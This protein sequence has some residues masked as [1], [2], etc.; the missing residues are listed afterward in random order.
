MSAHTDAEYTKAAKRLH[1]SE[2]EVEVDVNARVSRGDDPGAYVQAWVWVPDDQAAPETEERPMIAPKPT[3]LAEFTEG[4]STVSWGKR[5]DM[6]II[7]YGLQVKR[8]R[9]DI[10]AC[11]KFGE[12]VRHS[13][14]CA[15]KLDQPLEM[16]VN[17]WAKL[18]ED[19]MIYRLV[20]VTPEE[21]RPWT[22]SL[23]CCSDYRE[24]FGGKFDARDE[25]VEVCDSAFND[26]DHLCAFA[27]EVAAILHCEP[28][29]IVRAI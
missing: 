12:C 16:L 1:E 15:G 26:F 28:A 17:T 21:V 8:Y 23:E 7:T 2:G 11:H 19:G 25:I 3:L 27:K 6:H 4:D 9:D 13:L 20:R 24:T 29:T 5:G 22:F 14:E 10:G 18:I